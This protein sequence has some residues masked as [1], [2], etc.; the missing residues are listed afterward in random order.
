[1]FANGYDWDRHDCVETPP[2]AGG[3][4]PARRAPQPNAEIK[5]GIAGKSNH[6]GPG[7]VTRGSLS[8]RELWFV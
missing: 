6:D 7:I 4:R 1:M 5:I 2:A 3:V 8:I